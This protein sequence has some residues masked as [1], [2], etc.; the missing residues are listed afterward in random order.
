MGEKTKTILSKLKDLNYS[1]IVRVSTIGYKESGKAQMKIFIETNNPNYVLELMIFDKRIMHHVS[2]K[3]R[4]DDLVFNERYTYRS[5]EDNYSR[6]DYYHKNG[7]N[8]FFLDEFCSLYNVKDACEFRVS[9][10]QIKIINILEE[11]QICKI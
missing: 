1:F 3:K 5:H 8:A 11:M 4:T 10:M 9:M 7:S 2:L 6:I